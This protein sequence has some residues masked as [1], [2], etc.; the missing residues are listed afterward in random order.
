[1]SRPVFSILTPVYNAEKF[2]AAYIDSVLAQTFTDWE[3]I[4]VDDGSADSSPA[5]CDQY[6]AR[7]PGK[8]KVFHQKNHGALFSRN[9]AVSQAA[10]VYYLF[11]DADDLLAVRALEIIYAKF[12]QYDCDAVIYG[13]ERMTY[14]G[15]PISTTHEKETFFT[16]K[17][18]LFRQIFLNIQYN[19]LWR[20]AVKGVLFPPQNLEAF[21]HVIYTEDL[22][23]SL[24][25]WHN[26]Q[27]AVLIPD[28]LYRYR[29]NPEGVM[30]SIDKKPLFY[31][32]QVREKVLAFLQEE[33]IFTPQ[34]RQDYHRLCVNLFIGHVKRLARQAVPG[35]EKIAL[36][37]R[38]QQTPYYRDF[39]AAPQYKQPLS[40][41]Y[42]LFKWGCYR[43][44]IWGGILA[45]QVRK[46]RTA[47]RGK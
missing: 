24:P 5:I 41:T 18:L 40:G 44:L 42:L 21:Y 38:I 3:L 29:K 14:E 20:K 28:P 34:D 45:R 35:K 15:Q 1:M 13:V 4:L 26:C 16:D 27:T 7:F 43:L 9:F 11:P 25:F 31:S 2:L 32:S 19:P 23:Q 47:V 10:G 8:I 33:N 17:R 6:A 46:V 39:L 22:L 12:K 30:T 36:F 37:K